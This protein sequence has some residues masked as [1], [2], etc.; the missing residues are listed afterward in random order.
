MDSMERL[1][2][3]AAYEAVKQVTSGMVVGLGTGST[4]KHAV[5]RIGEL[6]RSGE[7]KEIVGI[8]SSVQT[9][10]LAREAGVPLTTFDD[11]PR[12][13]LTI[14]GADEVEPGLNLIKGGGGALLR[15]KI[16]AQSSRR[17]III[18]D[19]S[20][21]SAQ[22]GTLWSLPV[23]VI[24]FARRTEEDY[25]ESLGALAVLRTDAQGAPLFTDQNNLIYD[26]AFGPIADPEDLAAKLNDR[27]GIMAQGLFIGLANEVIIAGADGLRSLKKKEHSP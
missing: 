6:I 27:S 4:A 23:E 22:L 15:E 21:L 17:N 20:K 2:Q 7:L 5:I 24:P 12:I 9:E 3:Q 11:H 1:K 14:D 16:L 25:L 18:V 10:D 8:P 19:E 26:A 13:D